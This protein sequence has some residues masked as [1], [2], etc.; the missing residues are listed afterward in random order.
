MKVFIN[1]TKQQI[2][3][4]LKQNTKKENTNLQNKNIWFLVFV[5]A[6]TVISVLKLINHCKKNQF[7]FVVKSKWLP[8]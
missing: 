8:N 4:A 2:V 5:W 7:K 1:K 3:N 6:I